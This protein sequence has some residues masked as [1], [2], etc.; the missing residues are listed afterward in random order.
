MQNSAKRLMNRYVTAVRRKK[1]FNSMAT[2]TRLMTDHV[3]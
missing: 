1:P 3:D 2:M